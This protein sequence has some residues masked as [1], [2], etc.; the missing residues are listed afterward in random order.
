MIHRWKMF[1]FDHRSSWQ[2]GFLVQMAEAFQCR[3][4]GDGVLAFFD[5][6]VAAF[7]F[8]PVGRRGTNAFADNFHLFT[9]G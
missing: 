6:A 7:R 3:V 8:V 4:V 5:I 2:A 9:I 1:K